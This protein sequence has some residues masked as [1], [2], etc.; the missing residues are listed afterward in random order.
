M[1]LKRLFITLLPFLATSCG[2]GP[3]PTENVQNLDPQKI[4][5]SLPTLCD[6]APAVEAEPASKDAKELH[7]DDWR[8]IEFVPLSNDD[9]IR[10]EL[11]ALSVFKT[12]HQKG[13]GWTSV[14]LRKEHPTELVTLGLRV[15][16]LPGFATSALALSG[17]PVRGGFA[18][19]DQNE[20]FI[21]GQRSP[22]GHIIQLGV[23]PGNSS[24][25][26]RFALGLVQ[27]ARAAHVQL[28]D[29]Y[30]GAVVDAA[31]PASILKWAHRYQR[32]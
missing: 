5:F 19:T 26:Q 30:A 15:A 10:S 27:I 20:W 24:C 3:K 31:S 29:W 1:I 7:E 28:I 4:L 25:S 32:Q 16:S 8:Q 12:E 14:Y 22:D 2:D 18:L 23:S 11:A 21:Y 13:A 17:R 9:H 6:L